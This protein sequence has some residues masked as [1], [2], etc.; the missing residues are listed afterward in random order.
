M[1]QRELKI[2]K[3]SSHFF[4]WG[5]R[6]VG[7][8]TLLKKTF[9]DAIWIDLL[10]SDNFRKYLKNPE[11][12]RQELLVLRGARKN[13]SWVIID[14]I[15]KIPALLDE[16]HW[17]I[18]NTG[19]KFGLCGSS[20][21]KLKRGNANLLGG[22]AIRYEL[23]GLNSKELGRD[24][25][26]VKM[27]NCGYLPRHYK[28]SNSKNLIRSYISDYLK[29][30]IAAEGLIRNLQSF[31]EFL[32]MAAFSDTELVNF[33]NIARDC[34]VSS[35]SVKEYFQILVDTMLGRWLP[36]YRK[37]TKRRSIQARKFYFSDV[38]VVN[39]LA[40]RKNLLS[41]S[42]EFGKAFENW[43]L[44]EIHSWSSYSNNFF[45]ISYWRLTT[46]TEVDFI[47]GDM[48]IAIE[49]KGVKKISSQHLTGLRELK[50]DYPKVKKRIVVC[51]ENKKR[52][53][54]DGILVIPY[55]KFVEELWK[56]Q[57]LW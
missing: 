48:E 7:K 12:L 49:A 26:L 32:D 3:K 47:L 28:N 39:F 22:R 34:G 45:E 35:H 55:K 13:R 1:Y 38:G 54:S 16:V 33:S 53:T 20:A 40:K 50:K 5:P 56:N 43:I 25:N 51:F 19:F 11:L 8:S 4:L 2:S 44:H 36:A 52:L 15:Q 21:R 31:L 14:E 29:E 57:L 46:R 9:P 41:G 27:L 30:E 24:F 10:K 18:E 23:N 17:L 6:Q 37:K 42:T